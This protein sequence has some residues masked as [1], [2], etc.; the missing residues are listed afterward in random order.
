MCW[1]WNGHFLSKGVYYQ[2]WRWALTTLRT[3][4][5]FITQTDIWPTALQPGG[6]APVISSRQGFNA[7]DCHAV[8]EALWKSSYMANKIW[9]KHLTYLRVETIAYQGKII[10]FI[11]W[12]VP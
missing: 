5:V 7:L 10:T 1:E 4:D 8:C 6:A 12:K 11:D 9:E 2:L 3:L